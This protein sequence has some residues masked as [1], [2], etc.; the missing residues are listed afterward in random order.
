M[1]EGELGAGDTVEVVHRPE[2]GVT[3]ALV[4]EAILGDDD[5]LV[6]RILDAPELAAGLRG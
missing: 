6:A 3:I 4:N 1:Q 2:H 5:A